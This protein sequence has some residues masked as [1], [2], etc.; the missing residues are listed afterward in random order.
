MKQFENILIDQGPCFSAV[1]VATHATAMNIVSGILAALHKRARSGSGEKVTTTL[2][3]GMM[4]YDVGMSITLQLIAQN[5][6]EPIVY[7]TM[8][9]LKYQ[10]V[11]CADGKWIQLGN[12]LDGL[13]HFVLDSRDAHQ[14][15][16]DILQLVLDGV[17]IL[18]LLPLQGGKC[19]CFNIRD[20]LLVDVRASMI[21]GPLGR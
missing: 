15:L 17:G 7:P 13:G 18:A 10:P 2:L 8:P 11:Q 12:L 3:Q 14:V 6:E 19:E 21:R 5:K 20:L 1:Q 9:M 4:P 16:H